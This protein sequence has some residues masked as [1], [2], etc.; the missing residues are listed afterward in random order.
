[1]AIASS[2][3]RPPAPRPG[4]RPGLVGYAAA[5]LLVLLGWTLNDRVAL[6]DPGSGVGYW[7]GIVGASLMAVLLLYPIRK[8]VRR[9]QS[10]GSTSTW[11]R[12]HV[13]FGV[14][15]PVL[16]LYHCN[17]DAGSLN[18]SVALTFT[19][20]VA[21]SGIVGRYFHSKV[22]AD[23]DGHKRNLREMSD[24]ARLRASE[25][26]RSALLIP[27]LLERM[28]AFDAV[29]VTPPQSLVATI[30]HP[31]RVWILTRIEQ[32]RLS[33][34]VSRQLRLLAR[35]SVTVALERRQLQRTTHRFIRV[36]MRRIRRVAAFSSYERLLSLWHLFHL[37]FFYMLIVTA[38]LHILAV[39][40]Y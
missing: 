13:A 20:L 26:S 17:F 23:L 10:F 12:V 37:P 5:V 8:R 11:F 31:F 19:L 4:L 2:E 27:H 40:M 38:L 32:I 9:L 36:H 34:Y 6:V 39:H 21:L 16:I 33:W 7:L 1:M 22:Y 24:R 18:A 35:K 30:L 25:D 3:I 29:V 14:L 28:S 15:G